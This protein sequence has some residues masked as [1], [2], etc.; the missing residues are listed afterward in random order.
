MNNS[1]F[2][3]NEPRKLAMW[4]VAVY[5]IYITGKFARGYWQEKEL[6]FTHL[7]EFCEYP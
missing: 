4:Y 1:G 7:K 5:T 2:T 3:V 6:M